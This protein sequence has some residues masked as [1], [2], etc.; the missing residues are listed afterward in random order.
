ML[1][2]TKKESEMIRRVFVE[3][4]IESNDVERDFKFEFRCNDL[5]VTVPDQE[6]LTK[7][8]VETWIRITKEKGIEDN[9]HSLL[10][11]LSVQQSHQTPY[12]AMPHAYSPSTLPSSEILVYFKFEFNL[13]NS[14]CPCILQLRIANM[15][16]SNDAVN[17]SVKPISSIER[18]RRLQFVKEEKEGCQWVRVR[19]YREKRS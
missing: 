7:K 18:G 10:R 12:Q 1:D 2:H 19:K 4:L 6:T 13:H 16:W 14:I 11:H 15:E 8:K 5:F 17:I 3:I 9:P